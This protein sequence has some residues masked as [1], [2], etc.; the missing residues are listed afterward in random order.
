VTRSLFMTLIL[1]FATL[2]AGA[3][4]EASIER[5]PQPRAEL[6]GEGYFDDL[7]TSLESGCHSHQVTIWVLWLGNWWTV[8]ITYTHCNTNW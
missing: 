7:P 2:G 5:S 3:A 4:S 8:T 1:L 6:A